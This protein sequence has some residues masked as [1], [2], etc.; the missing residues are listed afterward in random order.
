MK[1]VGKWSNTK[2]FLVPG[3]HDVQRN[4]ANLVLRQAFVS[5]EE[6][7]EPHYPEALNHWGRSLLD[8]ARRAKGSQASRLLSTAAKKLEKAVGIDPTRTYHLACLAAARNDEA[9][10][11]QNLK[12]A[13]KHGTL[14]DLGLLV[15]D[16][17]LEFMRDKQWFQELL[18]R[19]RRRK[20]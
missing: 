20:S 9:H 18:K 6:F 5:E 1:L 17:D 10:C 4:K 19:Q 11:R 8:Q 12:N 7:A 14:P 3:N 2:L 15:S 13:E 16:P